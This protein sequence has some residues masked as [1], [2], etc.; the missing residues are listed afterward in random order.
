MTQNHLKLCLVTHR[1]N[2]PFSLYQ[3]MILQAIAGGVTLIQLRE[4][5][6][7][8]AEL[9]Q[10]AFALKALLQ[11]HRIPLIIND[12]VDIAKAVQ[13]DGVHLG[14]SD[15]SPVITRTLLGDDKIIGWSIESFDDLEKANELSCIDYVAISAV[16]PSKTKSNCKT[17]WGLE[18]LQAAAQQSKHPV[19][20]IGG[21]N[22]H[23][24]SQVIAQGACGVA[25]VSA[26][27]DHDS[28]K[29]A[30]TDLINKI[31]QSLKRKN[32]V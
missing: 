7:D 24:V 31:N 19:I 13:A 9:R 3:E 8:V 20:A 27:H 10:H 12:H 30:A 28:P 17:I 25:V 26:I 5:S 23:N 1:E 32:Y 18:G 22:Q 15:L 11:P 2:I 21:I 14:Q 29:S 16:F 4:K 6:H